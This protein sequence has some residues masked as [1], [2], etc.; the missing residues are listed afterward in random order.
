MANKKIDR[1]EL[2]SSPSSYR[3]LFFGVATVIILFLIGFGLTRLFL[4]NPTPDLNGE[5]VSTDSIDNAM[6]KDYM[7][8]EGDTLWSISESELGDGFRWK[9]IA[10]LNNITD[11]SQIETGTGLDLP[12][13]TVVAQDLDAEEI[14][15]GSEAMEKEDAVMMEEE[16]VVA[17]PTAV[18]MQQKAES[19]EAMTPQAEKISGD[20]YTVTSGE[21]LWEIAVRA[22]G[23]GYKWVDIAR[24]NNLNNPDVIHVGNKLVLPR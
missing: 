5:G 9:E 1:K 3:S 23:D 14:A 18:M 2:L 16:E 24:A 10:D 11:A 8:K 4:G 7:V 13:K 21:Y 19:A 17:T 20:N 6:N 22:Y 15:E 12:E